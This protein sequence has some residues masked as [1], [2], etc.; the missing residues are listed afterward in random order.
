MRDVVIVKREQNG[1]LVASD[2]QKDP[3]VYDNLHN[4]VSLFLFQFL[5]HSEFFRIHMPET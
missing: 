3:S 4:N 5:L 2:P 1:S